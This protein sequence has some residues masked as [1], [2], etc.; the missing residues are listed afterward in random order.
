[1]FGANWLENMAFWDHKIYV[2]RAR[3]TLALDEAL[4]ELR[5]IDVPV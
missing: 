1:M 3:N 5:R 2:I 4:R